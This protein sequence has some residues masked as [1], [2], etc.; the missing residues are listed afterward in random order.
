MFGGSG[1][2]GRRRLSRVGELGHVPE[3]ISLS[4]SGELRFLLIGRPPVTSV[5][6]GTPVSS[7]QSNWLPYRYYRKNE[8]HL[9]SSVDGGSMVSE[10]RTIASRDTLKSVPKRTK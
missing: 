3:I 6:V 1:L 4:V 8:T 5:M 9:C 2:P 10:Y 7:H